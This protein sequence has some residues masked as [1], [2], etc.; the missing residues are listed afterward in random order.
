MKKINYAVKIFFIESS[1]KEVI[2][3][4]IKKI[5]DKISYRQANII[6]LY[7]LMGKRFKIIPTNKLNYYIFSKLAKYKV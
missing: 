7:V 4:V 3:F 6:T 1:Y 2:N 5:K